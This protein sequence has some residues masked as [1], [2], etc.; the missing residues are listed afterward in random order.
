[1]YYEKLLNEQKNIGLTR[2]ISFTSG[3]GGVGKT[4]SLINIG[5]ALVNEGRRVLIL[6]A[7]LG[8]ANVD[9]LLGLTPKYTLED[10]LYNQ[11]NIEDIIVE[12]ENGLSVIPAGSGVLSL[13]NLDA[14][15]KSL[16]I[17]EVERI[18]KDYDYLLI[19]TGAGISDDVLFFN[20]VAMEVVCVINSEP[21]SL[22]DTYSLIKVLSQRGEK[23]FSILVNNVKNETE[24]KNAYKKLFMAVEKFLRV[25]LKYVGF[26]PSDPIVNE[27]ILEQKAFVDMY[28][29]SEVSRKV[30]SLTKNMDSDF[31]DFRVKGG[32]QFFFKELLEQGKYGAS[33]DGSYGSDFSF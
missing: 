22:T 3:K 5:L 23:D 2:V 17:S 20:T 19:D 28:P 24:A 13:L 25:K 11:K 14:N 12:S 8:L 15:K 31:F 7:D 29:S 6:D 33:L 4:N 10:L 1:M 32:I 18:A 9:I 27:A 26:I 16:I 30:V 21:T